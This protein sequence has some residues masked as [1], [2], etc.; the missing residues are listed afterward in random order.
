MPTGQNGELP[1]GHH[2]MVRGAREKVQTL[3]HRAV[4]LFS[5]QGISVSSASFY[6]KN[7]LKESYQ[8]SNTNSKQ[9]FVPHR[10]A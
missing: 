1:L 7:G 10:D 6:P 3:L 5:C 9:T 8:T 2:L 4:T